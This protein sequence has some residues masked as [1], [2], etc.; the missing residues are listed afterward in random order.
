MITTAKKWYTESASRGYQP[1]I[2]KIDEMIQSGFYLA[3]KKALKELHKWKREV[4]AIDIVESQRLDCMKSL[5][6]K[7]VKTNSSK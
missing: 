6:I 1:P 2:E 5:L 7:A 3:S 4:D